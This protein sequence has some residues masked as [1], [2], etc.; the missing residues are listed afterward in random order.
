MHLESPNSLEKGNEIK[1]QENELD[2]TSL[3]VENYI[4]NYNQVNLTDDDAVFRTN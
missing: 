1:Y 2:N 4:V 3:L